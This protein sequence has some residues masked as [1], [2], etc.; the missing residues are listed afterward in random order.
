MSKK[1]SRRKVLKWGAMAGAGV[2]VSGSVL[3]SGKAFG[4]LPPDTNCG[5]QEVMPTSPFILRPFRDPLPRP[6]AYR[7]GWRPDPTL[8]AG[9]ADY[10]PVGASASPGSS[11]VHASL[12]LDGEGKAVSFQIRKG[13]GRG[14]VIG[15][16]P[17]LDRKR[18][19]FVPGI[20]IRSIGWVDRERI[21][22]LLCGG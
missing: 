5:I 7:P 12:S 19:P 13:D 9:Q 6:A 16:N 18:F 10:Q 1:V 14:T 15:E 20:R 8:P 4:A 17:E 2:A 11:T 21:Y 22:V 3:K